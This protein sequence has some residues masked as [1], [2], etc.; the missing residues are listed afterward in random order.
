MRPEYWLSKSSVTTGL[1]AHEL[2]HVIQFR[3]GRICGSDKVLNDDGLEYEAELA[4]LT[5]CSLMPKSQIAKLTSSKAVPLHKGTQVLCR[6]DWIGDKWLRNK[7]GNFTPRPAWAGKVRIRFERIL[8]PKDTV[9]RP[10]QVTGIIAPGPTKGRVNAPEPVSG[11]R[12]STAASDIL[13]HQRYNEQTG[14]NAR[15]TGYADA[16]KGHIMA[17]ELGGPDIPENIVPQFANW[18][19]NG[20]WRRMERELEEK[21]TDLRKHGQYLEFDCV[22]EYKKYKEPQHASKQNLGFPAG[23]RVEATILDRQ[24][25][26]RT[27][28]KSFSFNQRQDQTDD[29]MAYRAMEKLER[30]A[31]PGYRMEDH[32]DDL[33]RVSRTVKGRTRETLQFKKTGQDARYSGEGPA[34]RDANAIPPVTYGVGN[35]TFLDAKMRR[36]SLDLLLSKDDLPEDDSGSDFEMS[37]EEGYSSD[38]SE[39]DRMGVD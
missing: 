19:A 29:M 1:L 33:E 20:E 32:Y 4:A 34:G 8:T 25:Q 7:G 12:V 37:S 27:H 11:T 39:S 30:R 13:S 18:Q 38:S 6:P 16:H 15:N 2:A 22:V 10:I 3:Q 24:Q 21:A 31:D 28:Y 35:K 17:L 26:N 5:A 23:F 9:V 14:E 36:N